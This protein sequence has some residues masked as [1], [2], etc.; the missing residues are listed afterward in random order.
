[1]YDEWHLHSTG[2]DKGNRGFPAEDPEV[3]R[4]MVQLLNKARVH[5]GTHAVGDH[6]IDWVVDTYAKVLGEDPVKDLRHSIIHANIPTDHAL[7]VM[8]DLQQKYQAGYPELQAPFMWWIGDNY[9]GNFGPERSL[10]L[11]PLKTLIARHILFSGGSDND[12]TPLPARYGIWASV[13]RETLAGTYG[14]H[15]FGTAEAIDVHAALKS[16]TAWAAPQLFLEKHIGSLEVGK[17]ADLAVWASDPY[18]IPS[19]ELKDLRCE[20]TLFGGKVVYD[21]EHPKSA[22]S[23]ASQ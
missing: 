23:E 19:A 3:Y 8:A 21:A 12:V 16:Y 11:E 5:I 6:A 22:A 1:V 20:L 7:A 18:T 17:Q 10:R 15:P 13:V 2:I 9:A 4:Q 14:L